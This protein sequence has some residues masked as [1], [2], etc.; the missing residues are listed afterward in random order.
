LDGLRAIA[1]HE[2]VDG[3]L[4]ML[5]GGRLTDL[6][7]ALIRQHYDPAYGRLRRSDEGG[8]LARVK[9][10][11][12]ERAAMRDAAG[13]I[14]ARMSEGDGFLVKSVRKCRHFHPVFRAENGTARTSPLGL[15]ARLR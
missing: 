3:W 12:L 6:S 15:C 1:G 4:A 7:E 14:L 13:D 8:V 5:G 2:A 11:T 10:P 9:L